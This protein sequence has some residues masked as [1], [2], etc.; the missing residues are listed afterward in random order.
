[1]PPNAANDP[2]DEYN[3]RLYFGI[4]PRVQKMP[5]SLY[6]YNPQT[7]NHIYA[8]EFDIMGHHLSEYGSNSEWRTFDD[9]KDNI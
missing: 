8:L 1:M 6:D 3:N 5:K 9:A 7:K 2:N 4:Y